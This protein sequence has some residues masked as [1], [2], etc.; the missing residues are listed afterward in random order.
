MH[1]HIMVNSFSTRLLSCCTD[2]NAHMYD[3]V[4]TYSVIS[5]RVNDSS[6]ELRCL[7]A[8]SLYVHPKSYRIRRDTAKY[9]AITPFKVIQGH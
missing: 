1:A 7:R 2:N 5:D 8:Q 4:S 9:T 3:D 6:P